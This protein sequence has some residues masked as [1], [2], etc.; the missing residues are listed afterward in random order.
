MASSRDRILD[1]YEDVLA[2][3]GE[4]YATLDAVAA[5]AGVSKGGLLYH[6]PSKDR[7]ADAL[8]DRLLTLAADD[9]AQMRT[10]PDGPARYYIRS[11]HYAGTPLD[12]TLVA[13]SRLQQAGDNHARSVI[14]T[15]SADWLNLLHD[16]LGDLDVARAVKLI[17][18]GLYYS[19]LHRALGGHVTEAEPDD[20][21]LAI[22]DRITANSDATR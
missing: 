2:V 6:F 16:A 8:C 19:A 21:L 11:S 3:E 10:A 22:I 17:G 1:A 15:V 9:V 7:L 13:V 18:D 12:R 14:E 5:K 4:R 20:G